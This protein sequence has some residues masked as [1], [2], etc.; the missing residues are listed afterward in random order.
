MRKQSQAPPASLRADA[1]RLY[2]ADPIAYEAGRPEYPER[3]YEVLTHRCGVGPETD[4]LEIG[5]GTGRV[6]RRLLDLGAHVVAIEPDPSLASHLRE[7]T[8][9]P[10][11][12]VLNGSFEEASVPDEAFDCVAAAMSFHWVDQDVG[13]PK[14]RRVL[15]PGGWAALWWTAFGD[16]TRPD[17]FYDAIAGLLPPGAA[18][19]RGTTSFEHDAEERERDLVDRAGLVDIAAEPIRWTIR[20]NASETRALYAST[21]ALLRLPTND[22][23]R[24]L[25]RLAATVDEQF[26]GTVARPFLT[27]L[28]TARRAE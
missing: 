28:Y 11:L 20:M 25:D 2:G 1:R 8:D 12:E 18:P 7:A 5:P 3:V 23:E 6:T 22:R 4:V 16:H 9:R 10:H 17:P 19:P 24:L 21:I 27:T 15:R 26:D 13:L 14:L